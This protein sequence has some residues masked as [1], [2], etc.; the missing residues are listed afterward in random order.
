[1]KRSILHSSLLALLC[2]TASPAWAAFSDNNDGTI[3]DTTT[4]L[5][6]DKC[7]RGQTWSSNNCTGTA[8]TF[9]WQAALQQA[10]A[11]NNTSH[12]G[13]TDWRL[14]NRTEVESLVNINAS[15]S[16]AIDTTAFPNTASNEYWT[17]TSYALDPTLAWTVLF[18]NG[19]SR[20][21]GRD[22]THRVRLVRSGQ[23][24][25]AF[26]PLVYYAIV[27]IASPPTAGTVNCTHNPAYQGGNSTCSVTSTAVGYTFTGWS[28]DCSGAG[29]CSFR[30]ITAAKSVTA[31]FTLSTYAITATVSPAAGGTVTCTPSPVNHGG[32]SNCSA[33]P[34]AG[35][36]F[37]NWGGACSGS[38][39]CTLSNVTAAPSVTA[40]FTLN[41]YAITTATNPAAGGTVTCTPNLVDHGG[42]STCTATASTGYTFTNWSGDCS[43]N[44]ACSL[45][46]V[47][48]AKS[49]TANFTLNAVTPVPTLSQ[50]VVALLAGL[51]GLA[52]LGVVRRR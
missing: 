32:N 19:E 51:L 11:A 27:A 6:W 44:G 34:N 10:T 25:G 17:S 3:T 47:T 12:R 31:N 38:G 16:P 23:W 29:A 33:T 36:T 1:M 35:Y 45:S 49:V 42:S 18:S 9:T 15:V 50:W 26:D 20:T 28:G 4:G 37:T 7:S 21:I 46:E 52:A 2:A 30:N 48:A 39:A 14:P 5:V 43:G 41:T 13:Q 22:K 24:F 8:G 40:N